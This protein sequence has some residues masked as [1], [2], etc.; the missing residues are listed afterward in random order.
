MKPN[1]GA[2]MASNLSR[3]A[4]AAA[5]LAIA[6]PAF[7]EV[8]E[9]SSSSSETIVVTGLRDAGVSSATKTGT[10]LIETS[11]TITVIDSEE[12]ERRNAISLNQAVGYVAGVAANQRGGTVSRYDQM[13]L[14]GFAPGLYLDG[15]R[16]IAG[17]CPRSTPTPD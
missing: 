2:E 5:M 16:L 11:Q 12:L 17:P 4:L 6:Q 8:N 1:M 9:E 7:A 14:R 3:V 15:M 13:N 10:P